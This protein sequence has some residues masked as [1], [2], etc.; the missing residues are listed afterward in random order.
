MA[1][2]GPLGDGG[3]GSDEDGGGGG[4]KARGVLNG[5][6]YNILDDVSSTQNST[7]AS[8][9]HRN[10]QEEGK[11]V[12]SPKA[13]KVLAAMEEELRTLGVGETSIVLQ[14]LS[15]LVKDHHSQPENKPLTFNTASQNQVAEVWTPTS[16]MSP[17]AVRSIVS[18]SAELASGLGTVLRRS[19]RSG[20]LIWE[21]RRTQKSGELGSSSENVVER[22]PPLLPQK[23]PSC[24]LERLLS[25]PLSL[26]PSTSASILQITSSPSPSPAF[27]STSLRREE[28][29]NIS[30]AVIGRDNQMSTSTV[31][32]C[33]ESISTV[34]I[35]AKSPRRKVRIR[36]AVRKEAKKN[37]S[38][39]RVE[40]KTAG[41]RNN[42]ALRDIS[43]T[44][45]NTKEPHQQV[46]INAKENGV[47]MIES[48][49]E[50]SHSAVDAKRKVGVPS[51]AATKTKPMPTRLW[52]TYMRQRRTRLARN[53]G[54][55]AEVSPPPNSLLLSRSSRRLK[56]RT[57]TKEMSDQYA[58][59]VTLRAAQQYR[60][61][62]SQLSS[63]KRA[64]PRIINS[65]KKSIVRRCSERDGQDE[66]SRAHRATLRHVAR[67]GARREKRLHRRAALNKKRRTR[68][69]QLI[70]EM[71]R[72]EAKQAAE[73]H[74]HTRV[75]G[76]V[77]EAIDDALLNVSRNREHKLPLEAMVSP[78]VAV[79]MTRFYAPSGE[80]T[81]SDSRDG[82]WPKRIGRGKGVHSPSGTYKIAWDD[83]TN[84]ETR[85]K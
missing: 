60:S 81:T 82:K 38:Q 59:P 30:T 70:E 85:S 46:L 27:T 17:S 37:P 9:V 26:A 49:K 58:S 78:K 61:A 62:I 71:R 56:Q 77:G 41:E 34:K 39:R 42:R 2:V 57:A 52:L 18:Q 79:A 21:E 40:V 44:R 10:H 72:K 67:V 50:T 69:R 16:L 19:G 25:Q 45:D 51:V 47:M 8:F 6:S 64:S 12:L 7:P 31:T 15:Y 54:S 36:E 76:I 4:K 35:A 24:L 43:E 29:G 22:M 80:A 5:S 14:E 53:R 20:T 63:M 1:K 83:D 84:N 55:E 75:E 66:E 13:E 3:G 65:K 11:V 73:E 68:N 32:R 74:L 23:L 33:E 28:E 48:A